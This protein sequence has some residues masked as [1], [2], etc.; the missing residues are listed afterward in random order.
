[1]FGRKP[2][3]QPALMPWQETAARARERKESL[4]GQGLRDQKLVLTTLVHA[5]EQG[6]LMLLDGGYCRWHQRRDGRIV[7]CE[8][9]SQVPGCGQRILRRLQAQEGVAE[10]IARCPSTWDANDWYERRGFKMSGTA[11]D[12]LGGTMN[13][14]ALAVS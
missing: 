3:Q 6:R 5:H 1:M 13:I 2:D 4:S 11:S 7:I 14:W 8:I 10:I 12:G 9:I